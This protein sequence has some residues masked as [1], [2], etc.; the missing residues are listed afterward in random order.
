M[1]IVH[2]ERDLTV[3]ESDE[4]EFGVWLSE[5]A[6]DYPSAEGSMLGDHH[7]VLTDELGEWIG[8]LRYML[9]GGVALVLEIAIAPEE[10][11]RGHALRLIEG[12]EEAARAHEAHLIEFWSDNLG[13]EPILEAVGW[14]RLLSRPAYIA[15]RTWHLYE[16]RLAPFVSQS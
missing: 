15:G 2:S 13:L 5:I 6:H 9:R 11:G 4:E 12:F 10:R 1:G 14:S 7:L 8:G 3:R 16:K